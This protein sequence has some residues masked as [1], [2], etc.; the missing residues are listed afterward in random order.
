[1]TPQERQLISGLFD[2]MRGYGAPDKDREAE[3]L[4]SQSLRANPD[5]PYMLVQ[6]VL[7]QE[8]AL[9]AANNRVLELED[10]LRA[11]EGGEEPRGS[12][13]GGFLGGYWGDRRGEEPRSSVPQ[14][15]ARATPS[16]YD[17][18][19]PWSQGA[20]QPQPPQPP[21][22]APTSSGG[23]F[24]KSALATAAGVAG[25]MVLADSIRGMLGGAHASP[26]SPSLAGPQEGGA[27]DAGQRYVSESDNDPGTSQDDNND[28]G[29]DPG[30]DLGGDGE[31]EI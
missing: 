27:Q 21:Q 15:G 20:P 13:S 17:S 2:R 7:V 18:R 6:S 24:M 5:A 30:L 22:Q 9:Q 11:V 25:G 14:V 4:I 1:M 28:P 8:Q 29:N 16:A 3:T 31:I 23:G 26:S 19:S 10:Q 12:R